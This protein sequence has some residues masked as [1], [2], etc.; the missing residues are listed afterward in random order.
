[1]D[2]LVPGSAPQIVGLQVGK[3]RWHES[4]LPGSSGDQRWYSGIL[5]ETAQS[6]VMLTEFNLAGDEQADE[7]NHG[8]RDKAVMAYAHAHYAHWLADLQREY[9]P[10]AAFGE[11]FTVG[12]CDESQVCIGDIYKVGGAIVQVSQPRQPCWKQERLLNASGL[13]GRMTQTGRTGWYYRV[14]QPGM[15]STGSLLELI[16]RRFPQWTITAA[17]AIMYARPT[18]NTDDLALSACPLLSQSWVRV[19]MRRASS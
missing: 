3:P 5:K 17:N 10:T 11:N 4:G 18:V 1:M 12:N 16:E 9:L 19:L 7:I 14:I 13:I 15:V 8:G 2:N 6:P